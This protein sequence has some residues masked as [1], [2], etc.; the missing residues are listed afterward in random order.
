MSEFDNYK[1]YAC[2]GPHGS[3]DDKDHYYERIQASAKECR[4]ACERQDWCTG[5]ETGKNNHCELW[6]NEIGTDLERKHGLSCYVKEIV[7]PEYDYDEELRYGCRGLQGEHDNKDYYYEFNRLSASE[8]R[9]RCDQY[10]WCT[11]YETGKNNHCELWKE[12]IGDHLKKTR[13]LTCHIKDTDTNVDPCEAGKV[14]SISGSKAIDVTFENQLKRPVHV[15]WIDYEYA[16]VDYNTLSFRDSYTQS[17]YES[18]PW[19]L[20]DNKGQIVLEDF[21]VGHNSCAE[22]RRS[23]SG[24]Q[25]SKFSVYNSGSHIMEL[26]WLNYDGESTY[27]GSIASKQTFNM[28]TYATH[29]WYITIKGKIVVQWTATASDLQLTTDGKGE[30]KVVIP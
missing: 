3:H 19:L 26:Y 20:S 15:S 22:N 6:E 7:E 12:N 16:A 13:G 8:C 23:R 24:A 11:G 2:R 4:Q 25:K 29:P 17:T 21:I 1:G 9:Y 5:Y 18:H 14:K 28:N 30:Y 10:D 27:Y